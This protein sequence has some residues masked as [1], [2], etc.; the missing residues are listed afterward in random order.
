MRHTRYSHVR[1]I[2]ML[3]Q[4]VIKIS[5]LLGMKGPFFVR[6]TRLFEHKLIFKKSEY[7]G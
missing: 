1:Q 2:A 7:K 6:I 3:E 4:K 5:F